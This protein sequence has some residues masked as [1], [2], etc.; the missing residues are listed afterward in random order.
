MVVGYNDSTQ[1][2]IVRN[3]WVKQWGM[4]GYFTMPYVYLTKWMR[5]LELA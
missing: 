4:K 3:S 1:R 5:R 2:F